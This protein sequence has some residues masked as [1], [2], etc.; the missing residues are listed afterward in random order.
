MHLHTPHRPL[1][2]LVLTVSLVAC[3]GGETEEPPPISLAGA[4]GA[5]GAAG[6]SLAG[7]GGAGTSGAAGA[8]AGQAGAGQGGAGQAGAGQGGAGQGGAGQGG[9]GQ[10]GAGQGG[11]G[12]SAG[13]AG[14]GGSPCPPGQLDCPCGPG[15]TCDSGTC[16]GGECKACPTGDLGCACFGDG[17]CSQGNSCEA[18][19]CVAC[20]PGVQG[21]PCGAGDTCGTDLQCK[22]N[23]CIPSTCTDGIQGCPCLLGGDCEGNLVCQSGLCRAAITCAE[24]VA[25]GLCGPEQ[26]CN[27]PAGGTDAL[28]VDG[29]CK[30]G[31]LWNPISSK[32]IACASPD[33]AAEPSCDPA[34][35]QSIAADCAAKT[36]ECT[37]AGE[38]AFCGPC[39]PGNS[40]VGGVCY[41][42]PS[43]GG[44][45]CASGEYCDNLGPSPICK[46]LPCAEG[47]IQDTQGAC[48]ACNHPCEGEG[49][50]GRPWPFASLADECLCETKPGYFLL[51]GGASVATACDAD[52]DGWVRKES[53]DAIDPQ[54]IQNS[55]CTVLQIDRVELIDQYGVSMEVGS[56][57]QGLIKQPD[58]T[59]CPDRKP[60][61]LLESVLVDV[62]GSI[63]QST[64]TPIYANGGK[65]GGRFLQARELN[66][67][68][69]ACVS[70]NGDYNDNQVADITE[71]QPLDPGANDQKRLSAFSFFIELYSAHYQPS[72]SGQSPGKLI[73]RE[74]SRCGDEFPL[75]YDPS[76]TDPTAS[77]PADAWTD[78][79]SG[80]TY[81]RNCYVGRD[82][83][84][85]AG[86]VQPG[87]D[88]A[89]WSCD[90]LSGS[91]PVPPP[92]HP[93]INASNIDPKQTL[94]RDHGLCELANQPPKD[95]L[96]RGMSHH[97]QFKCVNVTSQPPSKPYD[98]SLSSFSGASASFVL[99]AC[100]ARSCSAPPCEESREIFPGSGA[101][102]PVIDCTAQ[103]SA[104]AGVVGFAAVRYG[105]SG[106]YAG[107]CIDEDS[108]WGSFLCP[109]PQYTMTKA[110]ADQSFG[111]FSCY[112]DPINFLWCSEPCVP[113]IAT[114]HWTA[115]G[116]AASK[117]SLWR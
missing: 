11:A 99:N 36:R 45:L 17:S 34:S 66:A 1:L 100:E 69:K 48:I 70:L 87:F 27:E 83:S 46:A 101:F 25:G 40:D 86:K 18:G 76:V 112:G 52:N 105:T 62:P 104:T 58:S 80:Q 24:L 49:L 82:P 33:C 21:C 12:G 16:I 91:C 42:L 108:T 65:A 68:T 2:A 37:Q 107:G 95:N 67:L 73:L 32:C 53:Q 44:I 88:F 57:E 55:R 89:Q 94:L 43:C 64:S 59:S 97:S 6:A 75:R 117:G 41:P 47:Q 56:C 111:R 81:W 50:T 61:R 19:L 7:Q 114:L 20:I 39:L 5:S 29:Q 103:A 110:E 15:D 38:L 96:W 26:L 93:T 115:K 60:L 71:N 63:D 31:F 72:A 102:E 8:S 10:G 106:A 116:S 113:Q 90:G 51:S 9:A 98:R 74:R 85:D 84:Y 30:P 22:A 109:F 3:G 35:P 14:S 79:A 92:V 28:C 23:L 78:N 54:V 13:Q 4:G 77:P